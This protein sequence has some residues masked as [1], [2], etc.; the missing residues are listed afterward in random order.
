MFRLILNVKT[1]AYHRPTMS[2]SGM[3]KLLN[4]LK[5]DDTYDYQLINFMKFIF[6]NHNVQ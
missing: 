4:V 5:F 1:D 3:D 6:D 2:V